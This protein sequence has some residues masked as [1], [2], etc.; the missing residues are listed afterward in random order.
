MPSDK[1]KLITA[2]TTGL[3]FL[4]F[5][6]ASAREM[7]FGVPQYVQCIPQALTVPVSSFASLLTVKNVNLVVARDGFLCE[8]KSVCIFHGGYLLFKLFL[9]CTAV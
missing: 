3:I 4:L 5:D 6:V 8:M 7:P 1:H 2:N 9:I